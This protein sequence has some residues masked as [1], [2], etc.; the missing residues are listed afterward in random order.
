MKL[1]MQNVSFSYLGRNVIQNLSFH[2]NAHE[3]LVILGPSGT[4][5]TT[6]LQ[7]A[8]GLLQP[9]KGRIKRDYKCQAVVFQE[10]RLLPWKTTYENIGYA[11]D[12]NTFGNAKHNQI[13]QCAL[14]VGLDLNDMGKFPAALSGGMRQRV[15]VA[16][17]LAV[18][19]DIIFFDEPF[20]AVDIGLRRNLQNIIIEQ[21]KCQGFCS[22]FITHDLHEAL[23]IAH[24]IILIGGDPAEVRAE[25]HIAGVPGE[26]TEREIFEMSEYYMQDP[27]FYNLLYCDKE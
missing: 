17:A 7:L 1:E 13:I 22:L 24:R 8:A 6:I 15:A 9:N 25:R 19:P 23:R 4:G 11:L 16:R 14:D 10:P 27:D 18:K 20:S 2:L 5:K 3:T 21:T 26:R 12:A